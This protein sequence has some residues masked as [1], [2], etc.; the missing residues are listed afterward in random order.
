MT[1]DK[2][3]EQRHNEIQEHKLIINRM[4]AKEQEM[5]GRIQKGQSFV[6]DKDR[7]VLEL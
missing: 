1:K 4:K 6:L 5:E 2:E 3:L 7:R